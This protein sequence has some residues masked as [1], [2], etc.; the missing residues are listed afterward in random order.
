[1]A[2]QVPYPNFPIKVFKRLFISD[3]R[4]ASD[5]SMLE[6]LRITHVLDVGHTCDDRLRHPNVIYRTYE[7]DDKERGANI[8]HFFARSFLFLEKALN[9]KHHR[10]LVH[11]AGG[12]SR[13]A[14][15]LIAYIMYRTGM[16]LKVAKRFLKR[17]SPWIEP[18]PSFYQQLRQFEMDLFTIPHDY[19][20]FHEAKLII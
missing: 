15:V 7:I 6:R 14:T 20:N 3:V 16:R 8:R 18:N 9:D 10:V 12:V 5:H 13:S 17:K 19:R 2:P 1:M 11:C 4:W